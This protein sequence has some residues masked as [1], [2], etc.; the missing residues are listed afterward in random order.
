MLNEKEVAEKGE[1]WNCHA[2]PAIVMYVKMA[3]QHALIVIFLVSLVFDVFC[4]ITW[5]LVSF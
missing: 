2:F 5:N 1:C 4:F 3:L